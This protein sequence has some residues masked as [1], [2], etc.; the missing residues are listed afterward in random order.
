MPDANS[1][2]KDAKTVTIRDHHGRERTV[3][4]PPKAPKLTI[5]GE[6]L[7]IQGQRLDH[8]AAFYLGDATA[9]WRIAEAND[10][11][12]PEALSEADVLLIPYK[13]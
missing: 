4:L 8:L 11:M 7:R 12:L 1:R 13:S 6:H 5:R 2:Y 3:L 9:F 10:V